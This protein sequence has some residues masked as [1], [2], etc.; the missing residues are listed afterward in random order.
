MKG[1]PLL[2]MFWKLRE[3]LLYKMSIE[4]VC[5]RCQPDGEY[6]MTSDANGMKLYLFWNYML[7]TMEEYPYTMEDGVTKVT[8]DAAKIG[9]LSVLYK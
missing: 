3:N 2:W 7:E 8:M 6:I 5:L 1:S 4:C 9:S